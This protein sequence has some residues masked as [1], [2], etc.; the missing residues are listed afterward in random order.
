MNISK[1][2][3]QPLDVYGFRIWKN[4]AKK[5]LDTVLLLENNINL[6]KRNNIIKLQSFIYNQLSSPISHYLNIHGLKVI[7]QTKDQKNL[8]I[9]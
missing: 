1:G 4:F 6:H 2:K 8:K 5:F 3:I 9:Q 7:I